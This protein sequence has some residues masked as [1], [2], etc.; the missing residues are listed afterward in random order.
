MTIAAPTHGE[1]RAALES[2]LDGRVIADLSR[3]PYPY[4][5]S[6]PL[7]ELLVVYQDGGREVLIFKDLTRERLLPESMATKPEFLHEPRRCSELYRRVLG[8]ANIGPRFVGSVPRPGHGVWLFLEKVDGLE[9]WQVGELERWEAV[10][11][12]LARFHLQFA[13]QVERLRALD[14]FLLAFDAGWFEMW[15]D[16]ALANL[17]THDDPRAATLLG[18]ITGR[19]DLVE[20]PMWAPITLVH[21]ELY[22]S[23][24]ILGDGAEPRVCPID[25]EMAGIGSG[26]LDLA[27]LVTGWA[28]DD[29]RRLAAAYRAAMGAAASDLGDEQEMWR[30]LA[31]ARL[32]LALQWLGWSSEWTPP[33][34]HAHDWIGEA[35]TVLGE[36]D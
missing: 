6:F 22:P 24:I 10:A 14:P 21:G 33:R 27:A 3:R 30:Q 31:Q 8:P 2:V 20:V 17:A 11:R 15:G 1:L 5:T 23:N 19:R 7:E 25:W 26:Q 34:E 29:Q 13:D 36:L 32:H 4:A 18:A 28:D 12:W 16:R 35:L 9:L